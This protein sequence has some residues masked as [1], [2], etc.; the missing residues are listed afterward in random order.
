MPRITIA[1]AKAKGRNLQK[2]VAEKI[3]ELTGLPHGKDCPIESRPMGQSGT[4]VR[5][6]NQAKALF[7][8]AVECKAQESWSVHGWVEQAEK[9]ASVTEPWILFCKRSRKPPVVI[10]DAEVFFEILRKGK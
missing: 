7:P 5:L 10:M 1:S 9:N 6:D 4:D 2:W 3:S 8:F